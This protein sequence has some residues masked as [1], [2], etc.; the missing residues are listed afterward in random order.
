MYY[1]IKT[2]MK[3]E[4]LKLNIRVTPNNS[5]QNEPS[6]AVNLLNPDT[7]IATAN[8]YRL[9]PSRFGL[10]RSTNQGKSWT[11]N[12]LPLPAGLTNGGDGIVNWGG[13]N[14][15]LVSGLTF[16][17]N[18]TGQ[19]IDGTIVVY[20]STD[21]GV[22]F[23]N[24]IIVNQGNGTAE[25]N[26]KNY[27]I[28]DNS[29]KSPFKG[30]VYLS[31]TQF[32]NNSSNTQILFH[33]STDG[34]LTWSAPIPI[35]AV[36]SGNTFV[37]GTNITVGQNGDVYVAWIEREAFQVG[38][39]AFFRVRRSTDGGV[40]FGPIVTVSSFIAPPVN[41]ISNVQNWQFRTPTFAFLGSDLSKSPFTGRVYAV[42]NDY[43][44]G[45][46]HIVSSH[47]NDGVNWSTPVRVDSR[48]PEN[49]QNFFP[50]PV[51]DP[52]NGK[53]KVVYYTN[54]ISGATE[55]D[56]F[57]SESSNGGVSF[58]TN[59]RIS[60][61]SFNPNTAEF[62]NPATGNTT[63]IG[64]YIF[65][66]SLPHNKLVTVWTDTRT[67]NQDIFANIQSSPPPPKPKPK[68]KPKP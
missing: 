55:L 43:T 58:S 13:Q 68:P 38:N 47:S 49:T 63:F 12:I 60:D 52:S 64:D 2:T 48:S 21:N 24:P 40:T 62:Q 42:W 51:V 29:S 14:F 46:L 53:I 5:S 23:S 54:R 8:D 3:G 10:Y 17:R 25:F 50:F 27:S 1:D 35:T 31:Y 33:T 36:I 32:T 9:G 34:G 19:A 4:M 22:T 30:R 65:A 39:A 37:H 26:D 44:S 11:N 28:I 7:L 15:F 61:Q 57:V 45:N 18:A 59:N 56:V 66:A 6:I 41:L 16:N 20:R 67:G